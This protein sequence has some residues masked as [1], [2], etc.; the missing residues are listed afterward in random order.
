VIH[1]GRSV[2]MVRLRSGSQGVC[3]FVCLFVCFYIS[4]L[5]CMVHLVSAI[6]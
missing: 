4:T 2:D 1:G 3:L 6:Q 5:V